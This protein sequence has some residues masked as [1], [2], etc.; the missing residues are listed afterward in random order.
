MNTQG[1]TSP[2]QKTGIIGAHGYSGRELARLLLPHPHAELTAI[3]SRD[4]EWNVTHDLPEAKQHHIKHFPMEALSEQASSLDVVFLATPV[5]VSMALAPQLLEQGVTVIDLSGAFRLSSEDFARWYGLPH[6]APALLHQAQYGLCPWWLNTNSKKSK[7]E[8]GTLIS[9]P[10]CYATCALMALLPL[11]SAGAIDAEHII[12][13]AKS[14]VSGAGRKATKNKLFC[15]LSQDFYPYKVG[16]HQHAPEIARFCEAFSGKKSAPLLT[17]QLLPLK[18]GISM[19]IYAKLSPALKA[20]AHQTLPN[21]LH[22]TYETAYQ[23]YPLVK[24]SYLDADDYH[25]SQ[26]LLSLKHVVGS[27][28]T[29]ITYQVQGDNVLIFASLDN[30]MKGAASQAIENLNAMLGVPIDTGLQHCE[31][32][33]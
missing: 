8:A 32:L 2:K 25:S 13:D 15:E 3:F 23:D 19:S 27:A 28:R 10:G 4:P 30:L 24:Y 31:G 26:A 33:L 9:N 16:Q 5:E 22:Q 11:L 29:H 7:Q 20:Q 14:G 1:G 21:A 12:I 18:R 6:H 17:T